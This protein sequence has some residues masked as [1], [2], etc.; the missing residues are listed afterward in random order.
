MQISARIS[1]DDH[2]DFLHL[3]ARPDKRRREARI[4]SLSL[5]SVSFSMLVGVSVFVGTLGW[6][7]YSGGVVELMR[8]PFLLIL[9]V[10]GLLLVPV[11]IAWLRST[12]RLR[13]ELKTVIKNGALDQTTLRDGLNVG[14]TRFE[15]DN[16]GIRTS[17]ALV[18]E[19]FTW[20]AFQG[21]KETEEN[22]FLMIDGGSALIVPKRA[23][24]GSKALQSFKAFVGSSI[25][26]SRR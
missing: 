6:F 4:A 19:S 26:A 20:E 23:F 10:I 14:K 11:A 25:A 8:R 5:I 3:L 15:F 1:P 7:L 2:R 12:N 22:F 16:D 21:L 9:V 17:C 18:Q 24:S 13:G